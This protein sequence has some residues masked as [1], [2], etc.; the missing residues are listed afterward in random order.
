MIRKYLCIG[1]AVIALLHGS[2]AFCAESSIYAEQ[3]GA[4]I[5]PAAS[6]ATIT[7]D[8]LNL[9]QEQLEK[10][11]LQL[12]NDQEKL[13]KEQEQLKSEQDKLKKAQQQ[14]K[15]DQEKLKNE[16]EQL[17]KAQ[18]KINLQNKQAKLNT[19]ITGKNYL[20]Y[21]KNLGYYKK[22]Y[23]NDETLNIRNTILLFQSNHNMTVTGTWDEATKAMLVKRLVSPSFTYLDTIKAAPSN[24]KWI[25]VNKTKKT[26]TLYEGAKVIKKY[27][28]AVGNPATLTKSG[29]FIVTM[30]I[31]NP[32]WGG[33]G[34]SKP[35]K[36]GVPE[37]PLGSRWLGINRTDGSYGIH[38]T[39]SFYSIGKYI[40]HGCI[41]MQNYCV[42]ELY[43]LVPL[44]A[45]VWVGTQSELINWGVS[46]NPF[47]IQSG[48]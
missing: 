39:N 33:G 27:A 44:K 8:E 23:K 25:V 36:G 35:I 41:R 6:E 10:E 2:S 46:Q 43:P 1:A 15:L 9:R 37:N 24:G 12:K 48:N 3:N 47:E 20:G 18:E 21:L 30:K 4:S 13:K 14:L 16:Q 22:V 17:K 28:V 19:E 5:P 45:N 11:K 29:K 32:D 31:V 38:G 26:L 34:F 40:S 42:E 7:Q